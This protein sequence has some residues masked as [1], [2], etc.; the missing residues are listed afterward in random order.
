MRKVA[1]VTDGS[2]DLPED[3]IKEFNIFVIP[4]QVI[5]DTESFYLYG[6][7]GTISKKEFYRRL[8]TEPIYPTTAIPTPKL[9]L[10]VL[11]KAIKSADSVLTI[12]ISEK[13]SGTL[14]SI[15]NVLKLMDGADITV[16]DSKV[17][18][19]CLGLLVLEAAKLA[20]QGATKDEIV[21]RLN[22]IV[23][24][25][26]L[27]VI[28]DTLEYLH[29]GGRIGH[30]KKLFGQALNMKPILHFED[31]SIVSGGTIKGRNE[32]IKRLKYMAQFISK[33][34][35][36]DFIFIWQTQD[37]EV[38]EELEQI[39]HEHNGNNKKIRIIEAGPVI[40][41][42]VGPKSL[43]FVYIG[44]YNKNWLTKMNDKL[45]YQLT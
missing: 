28:V 39:I 11:Q 17:S 38:A 10:E 29:R 24:H 35:I 14:N 1:I 4:F 15:R 26:R 43:G 27:I 6:D 33:N 19:S 20:N 23:D 32:V 36:T 3:L 40:G 5:F 18:A 31:G 7:E 25:N 30:L 12:V 42:H 41:T 37:Y 13:L 21:L 34:T 44:N 16:Y 45:I 9:I 2:C 22:E 8:T